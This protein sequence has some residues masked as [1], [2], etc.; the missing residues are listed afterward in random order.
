M[1][2]VRGR[3]WEEQLLEVAARFGWLRAHFR[4]A[5]R[6][7]G[8]WRTPVSGDG[9]GFPDL[10]L[11]RRG[12]LVVVE[13]KAGRGR[14]TAEQRRWLDELAQVPGVEVYVWRPDDWDAVVAALR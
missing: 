4:P 9:K 5:Q 2:A 1:G 8:T 3:A 14:V 11:V 6:A 13:A 10:W 7:D 12:R